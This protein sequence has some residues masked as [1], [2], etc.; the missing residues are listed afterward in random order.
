MPRSRLGRSARSQTSYCSAPS[1]YL[2]TG[3][4]PTI[5]P[6]ADASDC[7]DTP[8]SAALSRS[9]RTCNSG[10]RDAALVSTSVKCGLASIFLT[11]ALAIS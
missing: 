5:S 8:R 1:L 11:T 10:L 7:T 9:M 6:S 4:P 2:L 3:S